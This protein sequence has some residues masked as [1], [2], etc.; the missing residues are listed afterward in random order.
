MG[1][2]S[3]EFVDKNRN[4]F[5]LSVFRKTHLRKI[6]FYM[7]NIHTL[8][9][10]YF[11]I[12]QIYKKYANVTLIYTEESSDIN[13]FLN[14]QGLNACINKMVHFNEKIGNQYV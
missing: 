14:L 8:N 4:H 10:I 11:F 3:S 12:L 5:L 7:I 2:V 1:V 13:I 6:L 9:S